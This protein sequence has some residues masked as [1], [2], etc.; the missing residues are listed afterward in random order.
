[1]R[2]EL[3]LLRVTDRYV[4]SLSRLFSFEISLMTPHSPP[5]PSSSSSPSA[6][7]FASAIPSPNTTALAAHLLSHQRQYNSCISRERR[8]TRYIDRFE[9]IYNVAR[10]L[11][12]KV[13]GSR[14]VTGND[15]MKI[16]SALN[17]LERQSKGGAKSEAAGEGE[18]SFVDVKDADAEP[19]SANVINNE[20]HALS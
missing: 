1:M 15:R 7:A 20:R 13:L 9:K 4:Y 11:L 18:V 5:N 3:A 14:G 17:A 2:A 16:R 12:E 8:A 10:G 19:L 6:Q